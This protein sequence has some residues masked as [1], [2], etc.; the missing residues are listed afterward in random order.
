MNN[1]PMNAGI[2][3]L[4]AHPRCG[5]HARTTGKPCRCPAMANGRCKLHGGKSPGAPTG[6][7]NGNFRNGYRTQE[8]MD[9]RRET[10]QL[11]KSLRE[12][13]SGLRNR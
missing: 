2:R 3:A 7:R 10:R 4:A 8:A 6:I 12:L 11:L 13:L 5:A 1:N 9:L